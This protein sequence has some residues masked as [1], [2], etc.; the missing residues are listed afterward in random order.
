MIES[1]DFRSLRDIFE[2]SAKVYTACA[3]NLTPVPDDHHIVF[4]NLSE[5]E[6]QHYWRNGLGA[7]SRGEVA[8]IVLAGGQSSR[9][10]SSAPKG[11]SGFESP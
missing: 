2:G 9:L 3:D 7:I 11:N 1:I 5:E 6:K 10:G 4:R 8:V